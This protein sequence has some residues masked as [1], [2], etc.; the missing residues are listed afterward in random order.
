M[1]I[2]TNSDN[3]T[4]LMAIALLVNFKIE[5]KI[6]N[7]IKDPNNSGIGLSNIKN[8]LNILYPNAHQLTIEQSDNKYSVHLNLK[9]EKLEKST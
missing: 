8:R 3:S 2:G 5:N 6:E 1:S 7:H 9:L 4:E